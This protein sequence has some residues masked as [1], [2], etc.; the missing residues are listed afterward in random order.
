MKGELKP[1]NRLESS[2]T[3]SNLWLYVLSVLK[4]KDVYAYVMRDRIKE[5]FGW[6]PGLIISY[7]VLYK[8]ENEG[9]ISSKFKGR[10]KYYSISGKGRG[11]LKN[12]KKFLKD[13]AGKL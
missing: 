5:E 11:A 10:R 13:L 7:M 4:R 2:L 3:K 6:R 8:L 1:L 9:L 12:G